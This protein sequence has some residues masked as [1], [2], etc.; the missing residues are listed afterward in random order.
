[1]PDAREAENMKF[2][3]WRGIGHCIEHQAGKL[4]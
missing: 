4:S 3:C 1:M 2:R